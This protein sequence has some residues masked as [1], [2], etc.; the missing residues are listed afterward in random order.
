MVIAAIDIGSSSIRMKIA[1][2]K[3]DN[4]IE[5][6]DVL[7]LPV[8]LGKDTF[9]RGKIQRKTINE[10]VNILKKYKNLCMQYNVK[11]IIAVATTAV[12]EASNMD[13]FLDNIRTFAGI[14][15]DILSTSRETEYLYRALSQYYDHDKN[16]NI[17]H[18]I[19]EIGSGS[20]IITIYDK[21]YI[22][23]STSLPVGIQRLKQIF[24]KEFSKDDNF[25]DYMSVMI[26]H[27]LRNLERTAPI[28]KIDKIFGVGSELEQLYEIVKRNKKNDDSDFRIEKEELSD[29][30][31]E[32][33]SLT[34]EEIFHKYHIPYDLIDTFP[35]V[36]KVFNKITEHFRCSNIYIP[37]NVA[38][39]DC[40]ILDFANKQHY[41]RY[42]SSLES[43]IKINA[44]NIGRKFNF[45]ESHAL[46]VTELAIKLFNATRR[47]HR[48]SVVEKSFLIVASILH[49]IGMSV[50]N[51]SHHKHTQYIIKAQEFYFLSN[52]QRLIIAN[53]ARYHRRSAPKSTHPDYIM[54]NH[55]DRMIVVKLA[56]I[57][58]IADSL[59]K[60][61]LNLIK[62]IDVEIIKKKIYITAHTKDNVFAESYAFNFKKGLFE[63][64]FGYS[65]Y[66]Q[67]KKEE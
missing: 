51:S 10:C 63:D 59:D 22:V 6:L 56:S 60:S 7:R 18:G 38:L 67:V 58:R 13:I 54:L 41:Q 26:D 36:N 28:K 31:N 45:N 23:Y 33:S 44:I 53:I 21:N 24:H 19:I 57:L 40:I 27:E 16:S 20:I 62:D 47:I 12:R 17:Y 35:H 43:Q 39:K 11:K 2:L 29:F 14:R 65:V 30:I 50:S 34:E 66:L 9:Y 4:S 8:R 25:D 1:E 15:V 64:F 3:I 32:I 55:K 37:G 42:Y 49:D 46:S 48:L 61:H 52:Y 5:V